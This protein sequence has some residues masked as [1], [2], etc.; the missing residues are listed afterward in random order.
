MVINTNY[1]ANIALIQVATKTGMVYIGIDPVIAEYGSWVIS[2]LFTTIWARSQQALQRS[3]FTELIAGFIA[4]PQDLPHLRRFINVLSCVGAAATS[5]PFAEAI[6]N[7]S[8]GATT[9]IRVAAACL[10]FQS[11]FGAFYTFFS[12]NYNAI[13]P[14][15]AK[16]LVSEKCYSFSHEKVILFKLIDDFKAYIDKADNKQIKMFDD[17]TKSNDITPNNV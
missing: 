3:W 14:A 7:A 8:E 4:S 13:I 10:S 2:G 5:L 12:D 16:T 6:W 15:T 1:L 9:P 17:I 11:W